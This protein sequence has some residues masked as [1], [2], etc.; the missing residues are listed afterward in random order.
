MCAFSFR[1]FPLLSLKFDGWNVFDMEKE[2]ARLTN[3][4]FDPSFWRISD[5]NNGYAICETY[6]QKLIVPKYITDQDLK[7]IASFRSKG[8]IPVVDYIYPSNSSVLLRSS[9]PLV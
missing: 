1:S 3:E 5:V 7:S 6:P 8:R 9:Q 2:F 4:H